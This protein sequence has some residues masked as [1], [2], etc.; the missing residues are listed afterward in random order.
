MRAP[1]VFVSYSSKDRRAA[2]QLV[3]E[4]E[5]RG[6]GCWIDKRNIQ[7]SDAYD[8]AIIEAISA[9]KAL[10]VL[11]SE[12][13]IA[14]RHVRSEVARASNEG[15]RIFPI[16]LIDIEVAGGLQFYLE[17]SQ[18]IDFFPNP[19]TAS[20]DALAEAI[21]TGK[22]LSNRAVRKAADMRRWAG[23][24]TAGFALVMVLIAAAFWGY[25][26]YQEAKYQ[27]L[28]EEQMREAEQKRAALQDQRT[29]QDIARLDVYLAIG[30]R[31]GEVQIASAYFRNP[32]AIPNGPLRA[33]LIVNDGP[34]LPLIDDNVPRSQTVP[35]AGLESLTIQV[36]DG[37]GQILKTIDKT[38]EAK[39]EIARE[40]GGLKHRAINALESSNDGCTISGC[41][42]RSAHEAFCTGTVA[43]V[44]LQ[45]GDQKLPIAGDFCNAG[46]DGRAYCIAA[47]DLPFRLLPGAALD[48]VL[49]FA[50]DT[51]AR[52]P[53]RIT[54]GFYDDADRAYGIVPSTG[55]QEDAPLLLA[56]YQPPDVTVGSFRLV[57]GWGECQPD[58]MLATGPEPNGAFIFLDLDGNGFV[59]RES[60]N[61]FDIYFS[62]GDPSGKDKSGLVLPAGKQTFQIGFG[63]SSGITKGPWSYAF[64][65]AAIVRESTA[66][67]SQPR[68]A[69]TDDAD[70]PYAANGMRGAAKMCFPAHPEAFFDV[71][72]V[73]F[74][75]A[76]DRFP[77]R[78]E[79][80]FGPSDY[81]SK[82]CD[83]YAGD[84]PP[85]VFHIPDDWENLHSRIVMN[86]G[87]TVSQV[88]HA[89]P[90]RQ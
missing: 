57:I 19:T 39:Q 3:D 79:F 15:K 87:E 83:H 13:S 33:E 84:C 55:D 17:L 80:S 47:R 70:L 35:V 89:S 5:Q 71:A 30:L 81:L 45:Q 85:F 73:E 20:Y 10:I 12:S 31:G 54:S 69:C 42:F 41:S 22:M 61:I 67:N 32:G 53:V 48:I 46:T 49:G 59:R 21:R 86:S 29:R 72:A 7:P 68:I 1:E 66:P 8:E 63:D 6:I 26:R 88:R 76:P 34:P 82:R 23:Y 74:G 16:R 58:G 75:P 90:Q 11:V 56:S 50:D 78:I 52:Q 24:T 4:L 9:S 38:A 14:S 51:E 36:L 43:S 77:A 62:P 37:N 65:P 64:D 2:L 27:R 28:A 25:G 44:A 60:T 18:W 40:M